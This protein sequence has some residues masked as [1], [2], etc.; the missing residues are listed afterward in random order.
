MALG[1]F[2]DWAAG[3]EVHSSST[4]WASFSSSLLLVL[5]TGAATREGYRLGNKIDSAHCYSIDIDRLCTY[6]DVPARLGLK[7]PALAWP[8][9]ALAFSNA[10]PGQSRT[11]GLAPAWLGLSRGFHRG[12]GKFKL[13]S[14]SSITKYLQ[15]YYML[16]C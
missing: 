14:I 2:G 8:E 4:C 1:P 15:R 6:S 10:G 9:A 5:A 7:A 12:V 16:P 13:C 11:H 3:L